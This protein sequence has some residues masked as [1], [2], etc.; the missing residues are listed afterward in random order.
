MSIFQE[1]FQIPESDHLPQQSVDWNRQY[2]ELVDQWNQGY[3][4]SIGLDEARV[5]TAEKVVQLACDF[6]LCAKTYGKIIIAEK[7]LPNPEKTIKIDPRFGGQAGGHKYCVQNI[8]FKFAT[9]KDGIYGYRTSSAMKAAGHDLKGLICYANCKIPELRLPLMCLVDYRGY[10]LIALSLLPLDKDSLILGSS[11]AGSSFHVQFDAENFAPE[12]SD[13]LEQAARVLN[14]SKHRVGPPGNSVAVWSAVDIEGH[15]GS[16]NAFYLLDFARSMPPT[17]PRQNSAF[18]AHLFQLFRPEF[19]QSYRHSLCPDGF[20]SFIEHDPRKSRHNARLREASLYLWNKIIPEFSV[21]KLIP[22]VQEAILHGQLDSFRLSQAMHRNGINMRYLGM[23]LAAIPES[24]QACRVLVIVEAIARYSKRFLRARFR[25]ESKD[26]RLPV[27]E[28]YRAV[29]LHF[30]NSI[31][32]RDNP[33]FLELILTK[34]MQSFDMALS[35]AETR[36]SSL[37]Q[38]INSTELSGSL[39]L[40]ELIIKGT[41]I[42]FSPRGLRKFRELDNIRRLPERQLATCDWDAP[43]DDADLLEVG[44][45]VKHG[46]LFFEAECA[47]YLMKGLTMIPRDFQNAPYFFEHCVRRCEDAVSYTHLTLPTIA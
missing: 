10:R 30:F 13:H 23:V 22:S 27:E 9:D 14:L 33:S 45:R 16:D 21:L 1:S 46:S 38:L 6:V 17:L 18:G 44:E 35:P 32:F 8:L 36:H 3:V 34:S 37:I 41:G 28:P 5:R 42:R 7:N 40:F 39:R 12:L 15:R 20:S 19:V 31:F 4:H 43:F 26:H 25:H 11:N 47:L 24:H 29:V 2:Q